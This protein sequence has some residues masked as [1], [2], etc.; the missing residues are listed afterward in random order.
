MVICNQVIEPCTFGSLS[1]VPNRDRVSSDLVL[2][3]GHSEFHRA[4]PRYRQASLPSFSHRHCGG[5]G[6]CTKSDRRT[7]QLT[8]GLPSWPA[9]V[10]DLLR[11]F[12]APAARRPGLHTVNSLPATS[13]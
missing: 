6:S 5:E 1:K 8:F 7:P 10:L 4:T 2:W 13:L 3:K 11:H 9:R 12:L